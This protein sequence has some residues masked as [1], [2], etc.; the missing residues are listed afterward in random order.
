MGMVLRSV[1]CI[2]EVLNKILRFANPVVVDVQNQAV[3]SVSSYDILHM[4]F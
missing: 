2:T 4:S 1:L 3:L